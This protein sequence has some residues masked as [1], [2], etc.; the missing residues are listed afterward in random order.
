MLVVDPSRATL[1]T[2]RDLLP[3][4][5]LWESAYE[6]PPVQWLS[7]A[8]EN[9]KPSSLKNI[10]NPRTKPLFFPFYTKEK[11]PKQNLTQ[12]SFFHKQIEPEGH[13]TRLWPRLDPSYMCTIK[14]IFTLLFVVSQ[15]RA[16]ITRSLPSSRKPLCGLRHT[17]TFPSSR[18]MF[19]NS[20]IPFKKG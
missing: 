9:A 20:V 5:T 6:K 11:S 18:S 8:P 10:V 4:A 12:L 7:R 16:S 14:P 2:G 15:P 13:T 17:P 19:N 1:H 3:L